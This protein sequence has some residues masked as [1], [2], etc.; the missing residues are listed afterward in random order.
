MLPSNIS[1]GDTSPNSTQ[2]SPATQ[3]WV[4]YSTAH[5]LR[6]GVFP[7]RNARANG[8]LSQLVGRLGAVE[9]PDVAEFFIR[10]DDQFY[11]KAGHPLTLLLRDA[12]KLR[13]QWASGGRASGSAPGRPWWETWVG[14]QAE[15]KQLGIE[16]A[17][18]DNPQFF[19]NAVL[20][21]AAAWGSLP[22][23]TAAKLG[24]RPLAEG[25]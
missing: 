24:L 19:R 5:K 7:V 23:D 11:V 9:A 2:I 6:Y 13:T 14:I 4:R 20:Q 8:L 10:H 18:F 3:A 21:A 25:E 15:A 17:K 12:E 16:E 1:T 22:A